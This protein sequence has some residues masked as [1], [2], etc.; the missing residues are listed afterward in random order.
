M[1]SHEGHEGR[2]VHEG[3]E[4]P[5]GY[6]SDESYESYEGDE[7]D[8][9]QQSCDRKACSSCC[10]FWPQGEDRGRLVQGELAQEQT[11]QDCGQGRLPEGQKEFCLKCSKEVV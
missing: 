9:G 10:T 7:G 1:G 3:I 8:E 11:G 2:E 6:E 4:M 5:E